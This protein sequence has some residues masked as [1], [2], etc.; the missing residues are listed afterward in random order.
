LPALSKH[1]LSL[2]TIFCIPESIKSVACPLNHVMT[3]SCTSVTVASIQECHILPIHNI[4]IN[5]NNLFVIFRWTFTLCVEK[6]YDGT[7]FAFGGTLDQHC[8]FKHIS[9]KQSWF[10]TIAKRARLTGKGSR[11]TTL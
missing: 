9:L 8:H 1:L 6:P 11:S 5:S 2:G 4:T 7:H 10:S 3:S